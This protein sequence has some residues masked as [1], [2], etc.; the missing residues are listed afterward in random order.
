MAGD[1]AKAARVMNAF[2]QMKKLD[3]ATLQRAADGK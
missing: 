3:I 2:M 1:P